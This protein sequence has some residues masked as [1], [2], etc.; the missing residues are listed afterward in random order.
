MTPKRFW[1]PKTTAFLVIF[2]TFC[3]L[4][5]NGVLQTA[6]LYVVIL[7]MFLTYKIIA[8]EKI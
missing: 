1:T 6:A 8:K 5:A 3:S 7:G 4:G 2:L